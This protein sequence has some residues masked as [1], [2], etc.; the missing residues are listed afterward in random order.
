MIYRLIYALLQDSPDITDRVGTRVYARKAPANVSGEYIILSI[1]GSTVHN[2]LQN[3]ASTGERMVQ[4]SF[5]GDSATAAES[6]FELVRMRMSGFS[7]E[8]EA[9]DPQGDLRDYTVQANLVTPNDQ[10][11]EPR[12]ASD[13]WA[14]QYSGDFQVFYEQ[15]APT[16]V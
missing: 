10:V 14:H 6:G 5:F 2:H 11:S 9:L 12:D 15:D 4:V 8:V 3:E 13:R 1:V 7:G 16:H